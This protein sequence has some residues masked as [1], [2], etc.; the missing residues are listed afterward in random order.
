MFVVYYVIT[1]PVLKIYT[2]NNNKLSYI[3]NAPI[4]MNVPINKE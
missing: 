3:M 2:N 1:S 4:K